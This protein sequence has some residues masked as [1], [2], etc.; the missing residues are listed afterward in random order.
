MPN[1]TKVGSE[2]DADVGEQVS[3]GRVRVYRHR[4]GL[5]MIVTSSM[6]D[7]NAKATIMRQLSPAY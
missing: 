7:A 1:A 3:Y 4:H 6:E 5:G 2:P